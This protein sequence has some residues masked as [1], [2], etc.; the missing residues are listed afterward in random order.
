MVVQGNDVRPSLVNNSANFTS[1]SSNFLSWG[2]LC[3][4]G[5]SFHVS[6]LTVNRA[7]AILTSAVGREILAGKRV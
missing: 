6:S 4:F 5:L 1:L 3:R 2:Q 7:S